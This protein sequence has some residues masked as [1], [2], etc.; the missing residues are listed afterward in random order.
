MQGWRRACYG[1]AAVVWRTV[2][3]EE[4][5]RFG[6]LVCVLHR[7]TS[8]GAQ[9]GQQRGCGRI[10][11][12]RY[13]RRCRRQAVGSGRG[14]CSTMQSALCASAS[15]HY[16]HLSGVYARNPLAVSISSSQL[17]SR[18]LVATAGLGRVLHLAAD[19]LLPMEGGE[20]RDRRCRLRGGG[21]AH[22]R[23][24]GVSRLCSSEPCLV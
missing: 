23:C 18:R 14:L 6:P 17:M 4:G 15:S 2:V 13:G 7:C 5:Y 21:W 12:C 11:G 19:A 1:Y 9:G 10:M 16:I 22:S 3:G 20:V 24:C 8:R